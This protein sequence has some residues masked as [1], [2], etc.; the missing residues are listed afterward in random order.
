[1][2]DI[3]FKLQEYWSPYFLVFPAAI[4]FDCA[5][6]KWSRPLTIA[7]LLTIL[8]FP[9]SEHPERDVNYTEHPLADQWAVN[10]QTA[11]SGWWQN[12]SDHRWIQSPDEFALIDRL[13]DEIDAGRIT[14]VT[15]VAHV[16]PDAVIWRD[17]LLY[18][19]YLGIDDDLY[20]INPG[21]DLTAGPSAGSRMHPAFAEALA[22]RPPYVVVYQQAPPGLAMPPQGYEEIFRQDGIRLFRRKGLAD[23]RDRSR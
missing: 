15:H 8:I 4:L 16:A 17:E 7:T 22:P 23:A 1:M 11:K 2:N 10:W 3:V 14:A 19:L 6:R 18:S 21:G 5:Y 9:W 12:S 13:R 20:L